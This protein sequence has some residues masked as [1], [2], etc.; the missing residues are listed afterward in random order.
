[1]EA[2]KVGGHIIDVQIKDETGIWTPETFINIVAEKSNLSE[3]I[4]D[5]HLKIVINGK[6]YWIPFVEKINKKG[7]K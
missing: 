2:E 4:K 1:M 3:I 7:G 5:N 6:E